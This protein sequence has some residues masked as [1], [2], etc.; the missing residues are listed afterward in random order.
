MYTF[1][2][3]LK[4]ARENQLLSIMDDAEIFQQN[5]QD[6]RFDARNLR[7]GKGYPL[8]R[9]VRA[10]KD[11]KDK[12]ID[13]NSFVEHI[14][15]DIFENIEGQERKT[16]Y[17]TL[18]LQTFNSVKQSKHCVYAIFKNVE[19]KRIVLA[20]RGTVA[21]G[22]R[23]WARNLQSR[24]VEMKTP[25][26]LKND[27]NN[28]IDDKIFVHNG[29]YDYIFDNE[30]ANIQRFDQIMSDLE[31]VME[32]NYELFVTGH[33]LGAALATLIS[34]KLAGSSKNWVPKPINLYSFESPFVGG[35]DF[36]AA[37]KELEQRKLLKHLRVTNVE[38]IVPTIP[39][40]TLSLRNMGLFKHAGI[41]LSLHDS[42]FDIE[43][44]HGDNRLTRMLGNTMLKSPFKMIS[45][46]G[47]NYV[48]ERFEKDEEKF[49]EMTLA[50]LY[51]NKD[52]VGPDFHFK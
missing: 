39:P 20:F 4:K 50:D 23:D 42:G 6:H 45:Y 43:Y 41:H 35:T 16:S 48:S 14:D 30:E 51:K 7:S 8:M 2:A 28:G 21:K 36:R 34:F 24:F 10:I 37:H 25:S 32:P 29:F 31:D 46:H 27:K 18:F 52:I 12:G 40:F 13:V 22:T 17:N 26:V 3:M 15:D 9:M 47:L 1:A 44:P 49:N 11:A 38:D 33:S 19:E 5:F